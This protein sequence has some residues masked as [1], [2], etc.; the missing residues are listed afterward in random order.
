MQT[1]F[2]PEQLQDPRIREANDILRKCVHCGFCTATCPT[3][4][5]LGEEND[6][7]RGRIY[8]IKTL[9]EGSAE[10]PAHIARHLDR[11]LTCLSCMTTCPSGVDYTHLLEIGRARLQALE[12]AARPWPARFWRALLNAVIPHPGR[13]ATALGLAR[14]LSFL[15]PVLARIPGLSPAAAMLRMARRIPQPEQPMTGIFPARGTRRGR[16]AFLQGCAQSVMAARINRATIYLATRAG[17]EVV[18]PDQAGCCGALTLHLGR[19][20]EA[21]A[22][23]RRN[24]EAW[25]AAE[26][27]AI[28]VNASGCAVAVKDYGHLLRLDAGLKERAEC[29]SAITR[30]VTEWLDGLELSGL[31]P[32]RRLKVAVHDPC[33]LR[34]GQRILCEPRRLLERAGFEVIEPGEPHL[35]CGAAGIYAI[36]EPEISHA[37]RR[38]K[39]TQLEATGAEV[40]AS[41]NFG[42]IQHLAEEC[43]LPVVHIV[44]LLAWAAGGP[45][46]PALPAD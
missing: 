36:L 25:L 3:Y 33:T 27:E 19:E 1:S 8:L 29:I 31:A 21:R 20:E 18:I 45:R 32:P 7:P 4:L 12:P 14:P 44:E 23:A 39:T 41:A 17:Y 37:L 34:H 42:C 22:M 15:A 16:V 40:V 24:I 38:R 9:L 28:I 6:S 2:S 10:N 5:Q 26:V 35:C 43:A 13:L 30:D 11:C 46:P